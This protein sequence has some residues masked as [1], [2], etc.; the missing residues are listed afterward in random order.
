MTRQAGRDLI[1]MHEWYYE[2]TQANG[3]VRSM[4]A[5]IVA[6]NPCLSIVLLFGMLQRVP[7]KGIVKFNVLIT[8]Y[9][10]MLADAEEIGSVRWTFVAVDEGQRLKNRKASILNALSTLNIRR[11]LLLSGTPLQNNTDELWSLMNFVEPV[12]WNSC[13]RRCLRSFV[14][15]LYR[16]A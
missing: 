6:E 9:E 4:S 2:K 11:R 10:T 16:C 7:V 3:V 12:G 13:H 14:H 15:C 5:V 1:R 8:S